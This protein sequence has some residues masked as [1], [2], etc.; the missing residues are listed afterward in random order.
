MLLLWQRRVGREWL[1]RRGGETRPPAVAA[2]VSRPLQRHQEQR[3]LAAGADQ[4][5]SRVRHEGLHGRVGRR[6]NGKQDQ[7]WDGGRGGEKVVTY[8]HKL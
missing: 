7:G 3:Q 2:R 1:Y 4:S 8:N 5:S 6:A